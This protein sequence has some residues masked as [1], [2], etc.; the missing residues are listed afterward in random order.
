M[1]VYVAGKDISRAISIMN[2]LRCAGH[3]ITYDWATDFDSMEDFDEKWTQ[4]LAS[5]EL[6]GVKAAD[7][8]VY[9][10]EADQ[11]SARYE[12]GMAMGLEIPVL[13]VADHDSLFFHL[14]TVQ[15]IESDDQITDAIEQ[16]S[17]Q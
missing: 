14:P 10:W 2:T 11:E 13:V 12:A 4:E 15:Q 5:D 16:D 3:T 17:F 6:A 9:L 7:C 1:K 8:L